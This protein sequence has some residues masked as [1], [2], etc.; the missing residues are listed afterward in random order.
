MQNRLLSVV[1]AVFAA[2]VHAGVIT[3][4]EYGKAGDLSLKLDVNVPD[5][6]GPFPVAIVV[7]GGGWSR[8]DKQ[9]EI[10]TILAPLTEAKFAWFSI[11]YRLAPQH[12][13]PACLEDVETAI[14]WVKTHAKKYKG[15]PKRVALIGYSAGGQLMSMAVMRAQNDTRVQAVVGLAPST[16]FVMDTLRRDSLSASLKNL[17]NREVV[18]EEVLELL[19]NISPINHLK[20]GLPPFLLIHGT[21]DRSVPYVQSL[22]LQN[23]LQAF[24]VACDLITIENAPHAIVEWEKSDASYKDKM[25][26]WLKQTLRVKI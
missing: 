19:W 16:D 12:R 1:I 24:G 5:G 9:D 6:S 11:N 15:D 2:A 14:R 3:D 18:N 26:V 20:K 25:I 10:T 13:F 22:H 8:G 23:R 4:I 21:Q 7:H 17:L